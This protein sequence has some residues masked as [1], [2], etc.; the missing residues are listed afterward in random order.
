MKRI[1]LLAFGIFLTSTAA[2]AQPPANYYQ[3]AAGLSGTQL[4][5]ALYN[6]IK[7]HTVLS[8]TP[9][10]WNA[11]K[12][13][14]KR[15]GTNFLWDIYSDIPGGT[16][17]YQYT[18]GSGQCGNGANHENSCYNR[19]HIW[20]QS[21]F[22]SASPMVSDL[23]IVY[24]TDYY[25]NN[26]RSNMPYGKVGT[27]AKTFL[28]GSKIGNNVYPG[29][30][31][32]GTCF[33]PIDSFKGDIARSYFYIATR[34]LGQGT[35][36]S[37][38]EMA[39]GSVLRPWAVQMLLEWHR[40]DPVSAKEVARN[41]AVFLLQNNRN[42]F[43]DSPQYAECIWGTSGNCRAAQSVAVT[44][45]PE[46]ALQ[47]HYDLNA[48]KIYVTA[49]KPATAQL[50]DVQGRVLETMLPLTSES[51]RW[52]LSMN[53]YP[54]GMYFVRTHSTAGTTIRRVVFP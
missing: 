7:G 45:N 3:S 36:W 54:R 28:N 27:A 14:D 49:D 23:W 46:E 17:P 47:V 34:Y 43:I 5:T 41:N 40:L 1:Y 11:Y 31:S 21:K 50:L 52:E 6:K 8:Y 38:W 4:Q 16:P 19:E 42:P 9:G 30:P 48:G 25:V 10:L 29:A 51:N 15:P 12:T 24:P 13:T 33:E 2:L 39:T 26:Q 37:T 44:S 20:P 22:G 32:A 53:N 18:L 35:N